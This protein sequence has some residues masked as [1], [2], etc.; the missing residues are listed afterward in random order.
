MFAKR[1]II[2]AFLLFII[3]VVISIFTLTTISGSGKETAITI[4]LDEN[5]ALIESSG[6]SFKPL[7]PITKQG[8][9]STDIEYSFEVFGKLFKIGDLIITVRSL[10][11]GDQFIFNKF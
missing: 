8:I 9:K 3:I 2:F 5:N 7:E 10:E 6:F 1:K 4:E 11:N